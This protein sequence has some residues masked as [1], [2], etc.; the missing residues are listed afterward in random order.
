M[1]IVIPGQSTGTHTFLS[2]ISQENDGNPQVYFD[3]RTANE[4]VTLVSVRNTTATDPL[5]PMTVEI[6]LQDGPPVVESVPQNRFLAIQLQNVVSVSITG[7]GPDPVLMTGE[8][9]IQ[10]TFC[11]DCSTS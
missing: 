10:Q 6:T 11:L 5:T 7:T 9:N 4:N 2:N 3:D 8:V 1:G